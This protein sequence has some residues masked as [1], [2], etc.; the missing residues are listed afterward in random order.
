MVQGATTTELC[1]IAVNVTICTLRQAAKSH[2]RRPDAI[3]VSIT[4]ASPQILRLSLGESIDGGKLP[5]K[6]A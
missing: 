5:V 1:P 3:A 6:I 2:F 4:D